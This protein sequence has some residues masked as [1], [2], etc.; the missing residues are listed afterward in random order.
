MFMEGIFLYGITL[1]RGFSRS[2][3]REGG[4]QEGVV[5]TDD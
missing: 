2:V 5:D 1:G 4:K 3:G